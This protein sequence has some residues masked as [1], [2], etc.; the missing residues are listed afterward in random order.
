M[1]L[2]SVTIEEFQITKQNKQKVIIGISVSSRDFRILASLCSVFL[3]VVLF[4][5][6]L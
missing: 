1:E 2:L 3:A 4:F 6:L 5:V